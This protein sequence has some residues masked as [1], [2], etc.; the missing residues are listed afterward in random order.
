MKLNNRS[1]A[2]MLAAG[3]LWLPVALQSSFA[4]VM[5]VSSVQQASKISG[6]VTDGKEPIIGASIRVK[7][8][9]TGAVTDLDQLCG[10]QR[11][12]RKGCQRYDCP[13]GGR[14]YRPQRG[15]SNCSGY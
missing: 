5:G 3:A 6:T 13:D 2:C 12:N 1:I 8:T 15:G 11:G 10:L 9:T 4:D 14:E 7:G